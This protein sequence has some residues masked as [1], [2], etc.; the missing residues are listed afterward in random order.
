M[1][2]GTQGSRGGG[3]RASAGSHLGLRF[4][5]PSTMGRGS[6]L[7]PP[8]PHTHHCLIK[9]LV[10]PSWYRV[11]APPPTHTPHCLISFPQLVPRDGQVGCSKGEGRGQLDGTAE[12]LLS[13]LPPA[14]ATGQGCMLCILPAPALYLAIPLPGATPC[15]CLVPGQ[16][17]RRIAQVVPC[18]WVVGRYS[19]HRAKV[20]DSLLPSTQCL[21]CHTP[22]AE[23]AAAAAAGM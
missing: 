9:S 11:T 3:F 23:A 21:V 15:P 16:T 22:T 5:Y 2:L 1:D 12:K 10:F 19:Q 6:I 17:R 8:P 13:I 7:P 4:K 20:L 14:W 18:R